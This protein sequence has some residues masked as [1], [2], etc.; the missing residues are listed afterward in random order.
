MAP[1][2]KLRNHCYAIAASCIRSCFSQKF[3]ITECNLLQ[4]VMEDLKKDSSNDFI[5]Q[6]LIDVLRALR[7][8]R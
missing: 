3:L 5:F 1:L 8:D 7:K 6:S 4:R 2:C